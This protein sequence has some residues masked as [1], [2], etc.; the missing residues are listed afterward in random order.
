MNIINN[1]KKFNQAWL[2]STAN[3]N[4]QYWKIEEL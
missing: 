4:G 3:V 2:D 1:D